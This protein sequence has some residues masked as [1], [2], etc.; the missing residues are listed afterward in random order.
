MRGLRDLHA[1]I[2][3]VRP[4]K[5]RGEERKLLEPLALVRGLRVF[6]VVL[7]ALNGVDKGEGEDQIEGAPFRIIR[8]KF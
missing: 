7:P 2:M 4:V 3:W 8:R 6:D 1:E 5:T